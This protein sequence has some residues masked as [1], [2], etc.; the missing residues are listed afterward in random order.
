MLFCGAGNSSGETR[1]LPAEL[2]FLYRETSNKEDRDQ[3]GRLAP[4]QIH[5]SQAPPF[6]ETPQRA[7]PEELSG[8]IQSERVQ[9]PWK[10]EV[11][12]LP[13]T[14][15]QA[16]AFRALRS[17]RRSATETRGSRSCSPLPH[18]PPLPTRHHSST[19]GAAQQKP[20]QLLLPR[21]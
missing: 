13:G 3:E 10:R 9:W 12:L 5:V 14:G 7:P 21:G 16:A 4:W 17:A 8:N 20:N 2:H 6:L 15:A 1:W 11:S 19:P 18:P